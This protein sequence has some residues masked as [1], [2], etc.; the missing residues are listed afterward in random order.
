[1]LRS[2]HPEAW[3]LTAASLDSYPDRPPELTP[4]DITDDMVTAVAERL[5]GGAGPVGTDSV[6]LQHWLLWFRAAIGELQLIVRD[7]T[8]W[9]GNGRPPWA[10]YRALMSGRLIAVDKQPNIRPVGVVETWR[11]LMAKFL[12][13]V[14]GPEAKADC[15]TV[16]LAG[17]VEAGIEVAI[18]AMRVLWEEHAQ[19]E[20]WGFLLID[21]Q[22]AFNEEN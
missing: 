14:T 9:M 15:G 22:N 4:V 16:Q 18:H 8:E 11:K 17:G 20:D 6:L 19:E 2:K 10:T 12:L 3:T 1:M 21:A 5:S 7:F 13:R